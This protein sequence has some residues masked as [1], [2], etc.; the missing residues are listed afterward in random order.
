M[1]FISCCIT[2]SLPH[3]VMLNL[4]HRVRRDFSIQRIYFNE[5]LK[6][7][8]QAHYPEFTE[9]QIQD[10]NARKVC[11]TYNNPALRN[12]WSIS[13]V[14]SPSFSFTSGVCAMRIISLFGGNELICRWSASRKRR[15]VR[16]RTTAFLLKRTGT[17]TVARNGWSD[18]ESAVEATTNNARLSR[19]RRPVF[20]TE[21]IYEPKSR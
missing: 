10:D 16:L 8:R 6:W 18:N 7:I 13:S 9:G 11:I 2:F 12:N 14:I 3:Y 1:L 5:I 4:F 21:G 15:F 20:K 19:Q 17:I